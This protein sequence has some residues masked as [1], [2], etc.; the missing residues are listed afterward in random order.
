[1]AEQIVIYFSVI[2]ATIAIQAIS[3]IMADAIAKK[4]FGINHIAFVVILTYL[5]FFTI[6]IDICLWSLVTVWLGVFE[7]FREAFAF[8]VDSFS[9][10]GGGYLG[11][12]WQYLGPA[13]AINGI[14]M[15]AFA[16]S[17]MFATIYPNK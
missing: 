1:M 13:I 8:V 12:P 11:Q 14:I 4:F 7:D 2:T 6:L 15:I 10:L 16:A 3:N 9:T 17:Y 5:T